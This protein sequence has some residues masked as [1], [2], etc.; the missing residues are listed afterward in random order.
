LSKLEDDLWAVNDVLRA[1]VQ[2]ITFQEHTGMDALRRDLVQLVRDARGEQPAH[3]A[4]AVDELERARRAGW[5]RVARLEAIIDV[6]D[7]SIAELGHLLIRSG[8]MSMGWVKEEAS[9][10]AQ[11]IR[12]VAPDD[13]ERWPRRDD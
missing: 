3:F 13:R 9:E 10:I 6:M 8:A 5:A 1:H 12:R 7:E 11:K 4:A 2:T